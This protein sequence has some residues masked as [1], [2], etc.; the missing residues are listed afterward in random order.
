MIE[1]Y[2]PITV[3][4]KGIYEVSNL[5]NIK[6]V[7]YKHN[8]VS[9][10]KPTF[11]PKIKKSVKNKQGYLKV[12]LKTDLGKKNFFVHRLVALAFLEN[13]ENKKTVNHKNG[14][15]D[16]NRLQNLEWCTQKENNIHARENGLIKYSHLKNRIGKNNPL[17]KSVIQLDLNGNFI[18]EWE[19][20]KQCQKQT[21][22]YQSHI[23]NVANGKQK[24]HKGFI[25]VYASNYYS[26]LQ[27]NKES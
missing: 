23:N 18:K 21:N 2:K 16:D 1:I 17:S 6:I 3:A 5:G 20:A 13:P 27:L 9:R 19:S 8:Y 10:K 24:I 22:F 4:Q 7:V 14:I 25:W 12:Q 11:K 15:K 26:K